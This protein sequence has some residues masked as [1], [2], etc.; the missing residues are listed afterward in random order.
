MDL[1]K[2][3]KELEEQCDRINEE[4]TRPMLNDISHTETRKLQGQTQTAHRS[5]DE[6]GELLHNKP[7][8]FHDYVKGASQRN[9]NMTAL[10]QFK[11]ERKG[12]RSK[13][14]RV[15]LGTETHSRR[16]HHL[17]Q[18]ADAERKRALEADRRTFAQ[19]KLQE[20]A[21]DEAQQQKV[22]V[23]ELRKR[24]VRPKLIP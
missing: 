18:K 9:Y 15:S 3:R 17:R 21:I 11:L 14:E 19:Q 6:S 5:D 2:L 13:D 16:L 8:L 1:G 12:R 20:R 10:E 22:D 7:L 24:K 23:Y 4:N